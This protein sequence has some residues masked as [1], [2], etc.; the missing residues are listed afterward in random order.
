META[1]RT[2]NDLIA[3]KDGLINSQKEVIAGM[4]IEFDANRRKLR[5]AQG[6]KTSMGN[7]IEGLQGEIINLNEQNVGNKHRPHTKHLHQ[8]IEVEREKNEELMR[9]LDDQIL[10]T[11]KT[12]LAFDTQKS[13][14]NAK[15]EIIKNRW[16]K[17][18]SKHQSAIS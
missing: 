14:L 15:N 13:L 17:K 16:S 5:E 18:V 6:V 8:Q 12:E 4:Q 11:S 10:I 7:E 1:Q 2:F 9:R 3:D